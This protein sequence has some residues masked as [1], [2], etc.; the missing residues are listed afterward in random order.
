[1]KCNCQ[2]LL[3]G[4]LGVAQFAG[5]RQKLTCPIVDTAQI[6]CYDDQ[7]EVTFPGAEA[8]FF[9]QD[10]HYEGNEPKYCDNRDGT[11]SDLITGLMWQRDPGEKMTLKQALSGA[12]SCRTG[13]HQDWRMPTIKELYSL[14][15]FSGTDPAPMSRDTS[16]L[17]P[18][19]DTR[20]FTFKY[21]NELSGERIID[22]QYASSTLYVS[23]TM[24]G[25]KT[26]F[27]VNF[28]DGRIKGYPAEKAHGRAKTYYVMYVRGNPDYG[29]NRLVAGPRSTIIDKATG[30]TW[31][32]V[33]SGALKAGKNKDGRMNWQ[34][35][36][37]VLLVQLHPRKSL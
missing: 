31:M 36:L 13:G 37:S 25:N 7:A 3:I 20:Y 8:T 18:F 29:K 26:M 14:I 23:T 11:V 15:I 4:F 1:M 6:R 30:L 27:G 33:D 2:L 28:A 12:E 16:K 24:G 9:G 21:G 32:R 17:K 22:S 19:I 34:E 35:E 10:A 5:A